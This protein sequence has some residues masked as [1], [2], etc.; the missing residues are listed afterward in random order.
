MIRIAKGTGIALAGLLGL[1]LLLG[2]TYLS[3][4]NGPP[5][6]YRYRILYQNAD[7]FST[8]TPYHLIFYLDLNACLSCLE[9][10]DAWR[11]LCGIVRGKGGKVSVFAPR[12]DSVDVAWAMHLEQVSDTTRVLETELLA[13]LDWRKIGTPVK[14]L[15]DGD[16]RLLEIGGQMG[17]HQASRE[18]IEQMKE[19]V[20]SQRAEVTVTN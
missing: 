17:G 9:D 12:S 14:I 10:M 13:S 19:R 2:A 5:D 6:P 15:L 16:G 7:A 4:R 11:E 3:S 18:F 8:A 1:S 20:C